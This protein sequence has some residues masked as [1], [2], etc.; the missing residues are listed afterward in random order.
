MLPQRQWLRSSLPTARE[1]SNTPND[2]RNL[3]STREPATGIPSC[4]SDPSKS[5]GSSLP[6]S[7]P[8]KFSLE[9]SF[10]SSKVLNGSKRRPL[11]IAV[12]MTEPLAAFVALTVFSNSSTSSVSLLGKR[13]DT[14]T[15][16]PNCAALSRTA[17]AYRSSSEASGA[18]MPPA[19]MS[20]RCFRKRRVSENR[21][22]GSPVR[23]ALPR[24]MDAAVPI[25]IRYRGE[26]E[27]SPGAEAAIPETRT[28]G[29]SAANGHAG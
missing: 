20:L 25:P 29:S 28:S 12:G 2:P 4:R 19:P 22:D 21:C 5:P 10:Q 26:L 11:S 18:W 27:A 8:A 14:S 15:Y 1:N 7:R 16:I 3:N 23:P 9:N 13:A 6:Y 24:C 17:A